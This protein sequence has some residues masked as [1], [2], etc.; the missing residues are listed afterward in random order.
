MHACNMCIEY[1]D[2]EVFERR[3]WEPAPSS[4]VLSRPEDEGYLRLFPVGGRWV[5]RLEPK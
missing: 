1:A 4:E 5:D 2:Q 3:S